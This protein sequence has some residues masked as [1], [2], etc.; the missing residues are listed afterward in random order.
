M[1]KIYLK[2]LML[3]SLTFCATY[4]NMA[5]ANAIRVEDNL[6][7]K[8]MNSSRRIE[9]SGTIIDNFGNPLFGVKVSIKE[10][11]LEV[12]TDKYGKYNISAVEGDILVFTLNGY[13]V[14]EEAVT[15]ATLN[16]VLVENDK[17]T[18]V[19]PIL[20]GDKSK[21]TN[22]QSVAT[23][24][25]SDLIKVPVAGTNGALAGRMAGLA[26]Y[27]G[28]GRPGADGSSISIRGNAP[29][30]LINGIPR[31]YASVDPEQ[32]ESIT[33]LKDGLS[34]VM[35]GQQ[36]SK[37]VV[38][39]KTKEGTIGKQSI[40]VTAQSGIQKPLNLPKPLDAY[41]YG[42]LYNE[43][44]T[45]D[46]KP[47]RYSNEDLEKYKNQSDP[48]SYPDVNWFDQILKSN[49]RFNRINLNMSGGGNSARY[50]VDAD[51]LKQGGLFKQDPANT[52]ST[53]VNYE[54]YIVRSNVDIDISPTTVLNVNLF[55]RIQI[56]NQPGGLGPNYTNITDFLSAGNFRLWDLLY[57]TP[58]NA[59]PVFNPNGSLAGTSEYQTNLW[60]ASTQSGY[61]FNNDRDVSVDISLKKTLDN[62]TKG[63]WV[64][65]LASFNTSVAE[66]IVRTKNYEVF[67]LNVVKTDS[68]YQRYGAASTQ[69]NEDFNSF[70]EKA[71]YVDF[72]SGLT[73]SYKKNNFDALFKANLLSTRTRASIIENYTNFAARLQYNYDKK[74]LAE[75]ALSLSG[76]N[77]YP[78]GERYGLFYGLG[79]GWNM[80]AESFLKEA[81]WLNT[82]KPRANY[83]LTGNA[84]PGYFA[85]Q[86]LYTG[87]GG[88]V[89]GSDPSI[90]SGVQEGRVANPFITWE[91]A[92]QFNIGVDA[93]FFNNTLALSAD[94]FNNRYFDLV[95]ARGRNTE[96]FGAVLPPENIRVNN[97][98][99]VELTLTYSNKWGDF[100]YFI[101]PNI[102]TIKIKSVFQDEIQREYPWQVRTGQITS[103][104]FGYIAD[105]FYNNAQD[106][107]TSAT[108][109]GYNPV[110]GDIKYRDLN[111]DGVIDDADITGL[112][113]NKPTVYYGLNL[114][115]N[116]KGF[117]FSALVQGI[118]N[119]YIYLSGSGEWAFQNNGLGQ[120]WEHNLNRWTPTTAATATQPRLTIGNNVNNQAASSFWLHKG[121]YWRIKNVELGY[122][123][124]KK[125]SKAIKLSAVRL[126]VNGVNLFT[127]TEVERI[128]PEI[129]GSTYPIQRVINGGINV[130]F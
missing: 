42:V 109:E 129:Y 69:I 105:G 56:G 90:E 39:V 75:V 128:D 76:L 18:N 33:I 28:N 101:S 52:Y 94:Y 96:I 21:E 23:V 15:G 78:K 11:G 92:K 57:A 81:T 82:L 9:V 64:K 86:Q 72:S 123:I 68:T 5:K 84:N 59:T 108:V 102:S 103:Q 113:N 65:G 30:V 89:F 16:V 62:I 55:G 25:N 32:I 130:K 99:G 79:L 22:L 17:A 12:Y 104:F 49:T 26:T 43:A 83:A 91:K 53:N 31:N 47:I 73:K 46:G 107:A 6:R 120:A 74:Y 118:S 4:P 14:K 38:L 27:Q 77:R 125:W 63:L 71:L 50:F 115:F 114:G 127:S 116:Y 45:N 58:N 126:F 100:N 61:Y 124:P 34:T 3:F 110:L 97:H 29:L 122:T 19:T 117:D 41:N 54:R 24:Y 85:Y 44:L 37:G 98:K 119:R 35:L 70:Q 40:S 1:R 13:L 20:Y 48:Y 95:G 2:Q 106:I 67:K 66:N 10:T 112:L 87:G 93:T 7:E 80:K 121:D 36:A 60:A 111:E 88:Y 51:Y 8:T